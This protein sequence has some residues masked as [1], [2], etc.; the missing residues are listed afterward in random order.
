MESNSSFQI[1]SYAREKA[2][3][4][5]ATKDTFEVYQELKAIAEEIEE[6]RSKHY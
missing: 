4:F 5:A 1:P 6:C 2:Y 3:D